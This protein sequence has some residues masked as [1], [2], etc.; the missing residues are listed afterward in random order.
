MGKFVGKVRAVGEAH[1]VE[2]DIVPTSSVPEGWVVESGQRRG[3][4]IRIVLDDGQVL[5]IDPS[6]Q[7]AAETV[8]LLRE[9]SHALIPVYVESD[10]TTDAIT[11]LLLPTAYAVAAVA[12]RPTNDQ[13]EVEL[14]VSHRRH[15]VSSTN[16]EFSEIVVQ[17]RRAQRENQR[18]LVTEEPD[19]PEII[20]VRLMNDPPDAVATPPP[21]VAV[22]EA[23]PVTLAASV[24][25]FVLVQQMFDM[26]KSADCWS[27]S[28]P[29]TCI[30]YSYPDDGCWA[31]VHVGAKMMIAKGVT[32]FKVWSYGLRA[33]RTANSP[34]CSVTW[35]YHVGLYVW[36]RLSNG[37]L[38]P[39]A[40]DPALLSTP[41][42]IDEWLVRQSAPA[43]SAVEYTDPAIY[44]TSKVS[45][46][47]SV[48]YDPSYV[49]TDSTLNH[50]RFQHRLR[51]TISNPPGPPYLCS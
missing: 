14:A 17:L 19:R 16:P 9:L 50:F 32:P 29:L 4:S 3:E 35:T 10:P 6:G 42:T 2:E 43:T 48:A 40:L 25:P 13:L 38:L 12:D 11:R 34:S 15:F 27:L 46:T 37:S 22:Q 36:A 1:G 30:P 7:R 31:R 23:L 28:A 39:M 51:C 8:G 18:V 41:A 33:C 45:G 24:V 20:D 44:L 5:T 21:E 26:L 49:A 47:G